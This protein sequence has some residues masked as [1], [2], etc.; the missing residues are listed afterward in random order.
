MSMVEFPPEVQEKI[1]AA[2][3]KIAVEISRN[4]VTTLLEAT[5]IGFEAG[6][7]YGKESDAVIESQV[8]NK[9]ILGPERRPE[10][11]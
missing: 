4:L 7:K 1:D 8:S 10:I 3:A 5:A 9:P 2:I 11:R 6:R